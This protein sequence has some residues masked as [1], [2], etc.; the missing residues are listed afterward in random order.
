MDF[1]EHLYPVEQLSLLLFG[2]LLQPVHL[3][4]LGGNRQHPGALPFGVESELGDL[5]LHAVEVLQAQRLEGV[6]LV[7]P[8]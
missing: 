5:G 7:G 4:R 1:V 6:D 8:A 2:G 3:V